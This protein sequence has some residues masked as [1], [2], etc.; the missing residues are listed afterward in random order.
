MIKVV[1]RS[2]EACLFQASGCLG[3]KLFYNIPTAVEEVKGQKKKRERNFGW[4]SESGPLG[5]A[6]IYLELSS[7][8]LRVLSPLIHLDLPEST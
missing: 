8:R 3:K 4:G 5:S 6:E 7:K 1:V 2:R